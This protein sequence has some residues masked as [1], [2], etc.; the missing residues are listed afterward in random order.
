MNGW[1]VCLLMSVVLTWSPAVLWA[2]GKEKETV[3][4]TPSERDTLQEVSVYRVLTAPFERNSEYGATIQIVNPFLARAPRRF[5]GSVYEFHR[6]D[7]LDARNFFDT[8]GEPLPEFKRNQFGFQLGGPIRENLDFLVAYDGLRVVRG[9]TL[10]S[11]V[12][13]AA[14][15][16]GDFSSLDSPLIDPATGEPFP[17]NIIPESRIHPV[18]RNLLP[19]IPDPNQVDPDRN[20]VNNDPRVSNNDLLLFRV[21]HQISPQSKLVGSY[22]F[23][24]GRGRR[25]GALPGFDVISDNSDHR[26]TVSYHRNFSS[27]FSNQLRFRFRQRSLLELS[28]NAGREGLLAAVGINGVS[29]LDTLDEGYPAFVLSGY[30]NF[31][32]ESDLPSTQTSGWFDVQSVFIYNFSDHNLSFGLDIGGTRLNNNRTGGVR[33]GKFFYNGFFTGDTFADFLLGIPDTAKRGVGSDRNDLRRSDRSFFI[34]DSWKISPVVSLTGGVVH[35]YYAP[36]RSVRPI[37]ILFPFLAEPEPGSEVI[38]SKTERADELGFSGHSFIHSDKNDWSP[39]L[40]LALSPTGNNRFVLRAGYRLHHFPFSSQRARNYIGRNYPFFQS[41]AAL[42]GL[43]SPEIDVAD[44]FTSL[45]PTELTFQGIEPGIRTAYAQDWNLVIQ[46]QVSRNWN[47]EA[48]YKG[49]K[50]TGLDRIIP[51]NVAFPGAGQIR[52]R[53]PDPTYGQF[54]IVS[55]GASSIRHGLG[56]DIERKLVDEFSLRSGFDWSRSISDRVFFHVSN[57]RDLASERAVSGRRPLRRGYLNYIFDLPVNFKAGLFGS[58][59]SGWRLSG[60]TQFRD[61]ELFTV[62]LPGD[63]NNDGVAGDRPLRIGDGNLAVDQRSVDRWF[64]TSAFAEPEELQFGDSG[65][66]IV[67]GPGLQ[68]WDV[69]LSKSTEVSDG[70]Q[71]EFRLEFFNALNRANFN[72]LSTSLGDSTFGQVFGADRAREI[73]VALKYSF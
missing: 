7:N 54:T 12:P 67:E 29:T 65:R 32:D 73:E 70:H 55:G 20:F 68:T 62:S 26:V 45:S 19:L 13:L 31:G 47:L 61:G 69:A 44:P 48:S 63:F 51:G 17:G 27:R 39:K 14:M 57:S 41:E 56:F 21:D 34:E 3:P 10:L 2:G 15:K 43:A 59:M 72:R 36:Y 60:I 24:D 50:G 42:S 64:D 71:V 66:N 11:H 5:H 35:N 58:L 8:P 46:K 53:R 28:E 30:M 40:G 9:Q 1:T 49:N 25:I 52:D 18:A 4:L 23:S 16:R 38:I 6:N 37:S 33:R 22:Q